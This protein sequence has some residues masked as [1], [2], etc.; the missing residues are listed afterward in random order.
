MARVVILL[1]GAL[2]AASVLAIT[3]VLLVHT[4][5]NFSSVLPGDAVALSLL[6]RGD[7][8]ESSESWQTYASY[9][10]AIRCFITP[11]CFRSL[12]CRSNT[13]PQK[14][15][16]NKKWEERS[17]CV[18]DLLTRTTGRSNSKLP[19]NDGG[20]Y[21]EEAPSSSRCLIYSV[22]LFDNWNFESTAAEL[23][24]CDVHAFDPTMDKPSG[25]VLA[26][27]VTFHQ[28]GLQADGTNMSATHGA[29]YRPIDP[30]RLLTL[31]EI[32]YRLGHG[33]RKIDL[34]VMDC[35]GCEW[36]VLRQVMCSSNSQLINQLSVEFHFQKSL[37]LHDESH[38]RAAAEAVQCLER[39]G[40]GITAIEVSSAGRPDWHYTRGMAGVVHG[41][42]FLAYVAL[43][44][45]D[46]E[47]GERT[48]DDLTRDF[49]S[50]NIEWHWV[51]DPLSK[52][53]KTTNVS[54][55]PEDDFEKLVPVQKPLGILLAEYNRIYRADG[56][57]AKG[58]LVTFDDF[59]RMRTTNQ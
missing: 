22:G 10:T 34:L 58:E 15:P 52:K 32:M 53:H 38:V 19:V 43:R 24:G 47:S 59:S 6:S 40:W 7:P 5:G 39:E 17:F 57:R 25:T 13:S 11:G 30:E 4:T 55:W 27:G 18:D 23:F 28:W 36:G 33:G 2:A 51:F 37:G 8:P 9:L 41:A 56:L 31:P 14:V 20:G 45:L 26:P 29:D 16:R 21:S 12:R 50:K 44:R 35:E 48:E 1:V 42:G 3:S 49:A 46:F 54:R